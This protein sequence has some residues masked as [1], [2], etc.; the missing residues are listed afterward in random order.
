MRNYRFWMVS[1][2]GRISVQGFGG[3]SSLE[4]WGEGKTGGIEREEGILVILLWP[5]GRGSR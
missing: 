3:F 1:F 4:G 2:V 5:L